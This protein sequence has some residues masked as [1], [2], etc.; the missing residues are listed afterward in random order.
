MTQALPRQCPRCGA[1]TIEG[2][3]F[4]PNCGLPTE[5]ML[6]PAG[7][8]QSA[9][10]QPLQAAR[11]TGSQA[12][13][14]R[15]GGIT[16]NDAT[17]R[18]PGRVGVVLLLLALLLILGA[19]G[20]LLAGLLGVH[21]P[22]FTMSQSP[23]TTTAINATVPYAGIPVTIVNVQQA[24]NFLDDPNSSSDGMLRVNVQENN[25]TASS[26][27]WTYYQS[28]QLLLPGKQIV[29]PVYVKALVDL[30]PGKAQSNV[31]D[32]PVPTTDTLVQLTLRLGAANEAQMDIPLTGKANLGTYQPKTTNV[33]GPMVYFGVNYTLKSATS[34]LS[35]AGQQASKG[36]R[37]LTLAFSVDNTLSQQAIVGSP[38]D[39]AR[40]KYG[41]TSVSPKDTTLPVSFTAG[42]TG[43]A[44]TITF[45]VPQNVTHFRLTFLAQSANNTDQATVDFQA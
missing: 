19:G 17:R 22:G 36:M 15:E 4:C 3:R 18:G 26:V 38:Y 33:N 44:G 45:Q 35:I 25:T 11:I 31:I 30:A 16:G 8:H 20:Y 21:L 1:P 7:V 23:I 27:R 41:S 34:S 2:E 13:A 5:A 43:V 10:Q 24:Q 37:Y 29:Q 42:A 14:W 6:A 39:Y 40:L 9:P 12:P 32:F 28:A